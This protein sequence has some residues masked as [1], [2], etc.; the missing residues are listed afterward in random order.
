M[1]V[2]AVKKV[3]TLLVPDLHE[4]REPE[5]H[6]RRGG[7]VGQDVQARRRQEADDLRKQSTTTRRCNIFENSLNV[8]GELT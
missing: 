2:V 4:H 1:L 5:V 3:F 8:M 7:Q 6:Q